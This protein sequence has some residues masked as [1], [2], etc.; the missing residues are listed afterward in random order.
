MR[1]TRLAAAVTVAAP[2]IVLAVASTSTGARVGGH[3]EATMQ[4]VN[5]PDAHGTVALEQQ[6]TT[7]DVHVMVEDLD[8][9]THVAHI[10]GIRRAENECPALSADTNGDGNIDFLEGF[11][12]YGPVQRTLST[13]ADQGTT[14]D[15]TRRFKLL[16]NGDGIAS[17]GDLS[18]YA[19]VIHGVDLDGDGI[20]S[21]GSTDPALN[22]ISMP[23][24]CGVIVRE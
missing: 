2:V 23:A 24:L 21:K 1:T 4:P 13:Q 18:Q 17:L 11:P 16:D 19:V 6:G 22:E 8:G 5:S 9:G 14:L 15:Y 20:A 3:F 12:A 10:H 7:L